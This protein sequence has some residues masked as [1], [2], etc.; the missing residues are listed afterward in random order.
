[1]EHIITLPSDSSFRTQPENK[2]GSYKVDLDPPLDLVSGENWEIG[3]LA[4]LYPSRWKN[5]LD[6][7]EMVLGITFPRNHSPCSLRVDPGSYLGIKDL[8]RNLNRQNKTLLKSKH[9]HIKR[10]GMNKKTSQFQFLSHIDVYGDRLNMTFSNNLA[11]ALGVKSLHPKRDIQIKNNWLP[12]E[13]HTERMNAKTESAKL[14]VHRKYGKWFTAPEKETSHGIVL[15][16]RPNMLLDR[17]IFPG[18]INPNVNFTTFRVK[19][20]IVEPSPVDIEQTLE[21][22]VPHPMT[23]QLKIIHREFRTPQFKPVR[24]GINLLKTI[25]VD[26]LDNIGRPVQ[27]VGGKVSLTIC[28]RRRMPN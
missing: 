9:W 21:C 12:P 23:E 7:N 1:M 22:F 11:R 13:I 19:T 4:V 15:K 26:I 24:K 20:N 3:L 27:F 8:L 17:V 14:E 18:T 28:V 6:E 2:I 25:N 5:V 16:I 10:L